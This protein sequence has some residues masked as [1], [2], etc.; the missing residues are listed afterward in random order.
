MHEKSVELIN[1][2]DFYDYAVTFDTTAIAI[3][4]GATSKHLPF[5]RFSGTDRP[6]GCLKKHLETSEMSFIACL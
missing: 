2:P 4:R 6:V 3:F 5:Q 1:Y